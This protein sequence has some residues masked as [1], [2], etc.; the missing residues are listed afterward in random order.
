MSADRFFE[1]ASLP[2]IGALDADV[3]KRQHQRAKTGD[4]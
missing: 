4:D 3:L 1:R 2:V